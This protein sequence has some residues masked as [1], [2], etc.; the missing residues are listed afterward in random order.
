MIVRPVGGELEPVDRCQVGES[1]RES[2]E[3]ELCRKGER[4]RER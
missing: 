2:E 4:E 3:R 1:E